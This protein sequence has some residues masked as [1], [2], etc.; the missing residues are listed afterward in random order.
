MHTHAH[1]HTPESELEVPGADPRKPGENKGAEALVVEHAARI[2]LPQR[3]VAQDKSS[4][5]Q[6]KSGVTR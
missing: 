2:H 1:T 4:K 3:Q 6:I 5:G